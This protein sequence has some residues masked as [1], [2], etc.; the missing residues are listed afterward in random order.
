[1]G[2]TIDTQDT[3][4]A[5]ITGGAMTWGS[6]W[7]V[8]ASVANG[9]QTIA[10]IFDREAKPLQQFVRGTSGTTN[11][12]PTNVDGENCYISVAAYHTTLTS[13]ATVVV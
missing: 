9:A 6:F 4:A 1:M 10:A 5:L 12:V 8:D 7:G 3:R 2:L 13:S 11:I